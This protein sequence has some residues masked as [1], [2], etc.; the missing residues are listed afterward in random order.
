MSEDCGVSIEGLEGRV[1]FSTAI[2][3]PALCL[4]TST[5]PAPAGPVVSPAPAPAPTTT[6]RHHHH[7]HAPAATPIP[8]VPIP[9]ALGQWQGD[10]VD[11][12]GPIGTSL[13]ANITQSQNGEL[14]AKFDFTGGLSLH[15]TAQVAYDSVTQHFQVWIVSPKLVVKIEG[16]PFTNSD[17]ITQLQTRIQYY[18]RHGAVSGQVTLQHSDNRA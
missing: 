8:V 9:V 17:G 12:N 11:A 16:Q 3:A 4:P 10:L 2:F 6:V 13:A 5:L 1:L 7:H 18:T 15:G 14:F